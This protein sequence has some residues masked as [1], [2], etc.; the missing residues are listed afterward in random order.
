[1]TLFMKLFRSTFPQ[2]IS[3][4][5]QILDGIFTRRDIVTNMEPYFGIGMNL[6][7]LNIFAAKLKYPDSWNLFT[8]LATQ[9]KEGL[10]IM[11][12]QLEAGCGQ[13]LAKEMLTNALMQCCCI[14][15][16][17][18]LPTLLMWGVTQPL[19]ADRTCVLAQFRF[20]RSYLSSNIECFFGTVINN[21][22]SRTKMSCPRLSSSHSKRISISYEDH[23][24]DN[25]KQL[26]SL[27]SDE[28]INEKRTM[29]LY[30]LR[31]V[32]YDEE[33]ALLCRWDRISTFGKDHS[34]Q[35]QLLSVLL[36][37]HKTFMDCSIFGQLKISADISFTLMEII[38]SFIM[39]GNN[40]LR[41]EMYQNIIKPYWVTIAN[42][43]FDLSFSKLDLF[44]KLISNMIRLVRDIFLYCG[45][46]CED[47]SEL[48]ELVDDIFENKCLHSILC[49]D[50][51]SRI[52]NLGN[53]NTTHLII[54][55]DIMEL[56]DTIY[57]KSFY[58]DGIESKMNKLFVEKEYFQSGLWKPHFTLYEILC[59]YY[60]FC[61]R[62][63]SSVQNS[64]R[65][66]I[67][68]NIFSMLSTDIR[69]CHI[70][71][72][73]FELVDDLSS[74]TVILKK[75]LS[76]GKC[77]E[78]IFNSSLFVNWNSFDSG[79][80]ISAERLLA[81]THT[82]NFLRTLCPAFQFQTANDADLHGT[83]RFLTLFLRNCYNTEQ[84]S[85]LF[86]D[87]NVF[88]SSFLFTVNQFLNLI[89]NLKD[90]IV[91]SFANDIQLLF[92]NIEKRTNHL[93]STFLQKDL[94][95]LQLQYKQH[96]SNL[97]LDVSFFRILWL[98][99]EESW[100]AYFQTHVAMDS[101]KENFA[102]CEQIITQHRYKFCNLQSFESICQHYYN[103]VWT[104]STV[105]KGLIVWKITCLQQRIFLMS[106]LGFIRGLLPNSQNS[107][108]RY[109]DTSAVDI[110][111]NIPVI[112]N[113]L[114]RNYSVYQK[115][116]WKCFI[117]TMI[118]HIFCE[119]YGNDNR[120]V[121]TYQKTRELFDELKLK[122]CG[123][124]DVK[125]AS[126]SPT[127][128]HPFPILAYQLAL[129]PYELLF[130]L[131]PFKQFKLWFK[132]L[133]FYELNVSYELFEYSCLPI[134]RFMYISKLATT[135]HL[136]RWFN[137]L[138]V[139]ESL[140]QPISEDLTQIFHGW[141]FHLVKQQCKAT[142]NDKRA[143]F[144]LRIG[145]ILGFIDAKYYSYGGTVSESTLEKP[146]KSILNPHS[147]T[148]GMHEIIC[149]YLNQHIDAF[150][151]QLISYEIHALIVSFFCTPYFPH[152][153]RKKIFFE[154]REMKLVHLLESDS[155]VMIFNLLDSAN[156][157]FSR[158]TQIVNSKN[159]RIN[160]DEV[161]EYSL[162]QQILE[163]L[164]TSLRNEATDKSLRIVELLIS[165]MSSYFFSNTQTEK[166]CLSG[167]AG[168]LFGELI[169]TNLSSPF[170][171]PDW[172][173]IGI[174]SKLLIFSKMNA[175][176][177]HVKSDKVFDANCLFHFCRTFTIMIDKGPLSFMNNGLW[178]IHNLLTTFRK[179]IADE[180]FTNDINPVST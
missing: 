170:I 107:R 18:N 64:L 7:E 131:Q 58:T 108:L 34:L 35:L 154:L 153:F 168:R 57:Q 92:C 5:A 33:F 13:L 61:D 132:V 128:Y 174:I 123:T 148:T 8:K 45:D 29:P 77:I 125:T 178:S 119:Q 72:R 158:E 91:F 137:N 59:K 87:A 38:R 3:L 122:L 19:K 63:G 155:S 133:S 126:L 115:S 156:N 16:P 70:Y 75:L 151:N 4:A 46:A 144:P 21:W 22:F 99:F 47:C 135:E 166:W 69:W 114:Q 73:N 50:T 65:I 176:F 67:E 54:I 140:Q 26:R 180:L 43:K 17:P 52:M 147:T 85:D 79:I 97:I 127:S 39:H 93:I 53:E 94:L 130:S 111:K 55:G 172:L 102:V 145:D 15:V 82:M 106:T 138:S 136:F 23:A 24:I 150:A 105:N 83:E 171:V 101:F 161:E 84:L 12:S 165:T 1:M 175:N 88:P 134:H 179:T 48:L 37:E 142:T 167:L 143:S 44:L 98:E 89:I 177:G 71:I 41:F 152:R 74:I 31:Q 30:N 6:D 51:F 49:E 121:K 104:L 113:L 112:I 56:V 163:L 116:L 149:Q 95:S 80:A 118:E 110:L 36:Q 20:L 141:L 68:N 117:S 120:P 10:D 9:Y 90:P 14:T 96:E 27:V 62:K 78:M 2:Q 103:N 124:I 81:A 100:L 139:E 146:F 109:D 32:S 173:I 162:M 28:E 25:E 11:T 157:D 66:T 42:A 60:E 159:S 169:H 86:G 164:S 40:I 76:V 129:L 160:L